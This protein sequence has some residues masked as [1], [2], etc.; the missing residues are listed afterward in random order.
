MADEIVTQVD[1]S[2]R[3]V[4]QN[5]TRGEH[6]YLFSRHHIDFDSFEKFV[7]YLYYRERV[8]PWLLNF[9]APMVLNLRKP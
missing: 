7:D 3:I 4:Q 8:A 1:D 2:G 6:R 9:D 5:I